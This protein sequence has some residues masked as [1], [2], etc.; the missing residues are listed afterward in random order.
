MLFTDIIP[1]YGENHTKRTTSESSSPNRM[2]PCHR[3]SIHANAQN[4]PAFTAGGISEAEMATPTR[5]AV[6]STRMAMATAAPEGSATSSPTHKDL[7]WPL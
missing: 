3:I 6:L 1:V 2:R 7:I 4:N 5:D